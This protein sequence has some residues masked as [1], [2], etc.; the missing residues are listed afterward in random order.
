MSEKI[1]SI[2]IGG[3]ATGV[4]A[5]LLSI[6]QNQCLGCVVCLLYAG[7]GV[8]AVWHYTKEHSLTMTGGEGAGIGAMAGIVAGIIVIIL[9]LIFRAIGLLPGPEEIITQLEESGQFDQLS[10]DQLDMVMGILDF[11]MGVGG[12]VLT[13]VFSVIMAVIGGIIGASIFKKGSDTPA[14]GDAAAE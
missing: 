13:I 3:V 11:M 5:V 1:P 6:P 9:S 12:Y 7:A 8:L 14:E 4:V 2:L 10:D